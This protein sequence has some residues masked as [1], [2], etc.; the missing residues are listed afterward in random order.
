M[1]S[2]EPSLMV[3]LLVYR[4]ATYAQMGNMVMLAV[5]LLVRIVN[6]QLLI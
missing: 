2:R 4:T 1:Y 3:F 6:N 5:F